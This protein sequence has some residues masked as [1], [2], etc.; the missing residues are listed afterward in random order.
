M[1]KVIKEIQKIFTDYGWGSAHFRKEE[2]RK[3]LSEWRKAWGQRIVAEHDK[4]VRANLGPS[5]P[6]PLDEFSD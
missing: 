5:P 2:C 3:A 4:L 1:L 6:D